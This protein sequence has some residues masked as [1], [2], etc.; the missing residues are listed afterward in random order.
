MILRKWAPFI[1]IVPL[2]VLIDQ[3]TKTWVLENMQLYETIEI[4]PPYFQF[5]RSFNTGAAFGILPDAGPA[6]LVVAIVISLVILFLYHGSSAQARLMH[7]GFSLVVGGALGNVIDRA[8]HGEV[9]D[10]IHYRLPNVFSN[11]SNLADHA[12]VIGVGILLVDN[13]LHNRAAQPPPE[14]D[15]A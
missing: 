13:L 4:I 7:L 1:A 3:L 14:H 5:T 12:I 15:D 10:F 2:V 11:V 8:L 6:F 9:I